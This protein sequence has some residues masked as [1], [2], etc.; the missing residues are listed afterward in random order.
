MNDVEKEVVQERFNKYV[1]KQGN[2][3]CWLWKGAIK[4]KGYGGFGV[5]GRVWL[6]HR[7]AYFL[8]FNFLPKNLCVC[9]SC[10]NPSCVNPKHLW[11]GT[12]KQNVEDRVRKGRGKCGNLKGEDH[13]GHKLTEKDVLKIRK[14]GKRYTQ[15]ILA[16]KFG[17]SRRLIGMIIKKKIWRHI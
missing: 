5:G 16:K 2:D 11:L 10:D 12:N 8:E 3:V 14:V 17:V 9:H 4:V 13:G 6:T 1:L 7:L 15:E